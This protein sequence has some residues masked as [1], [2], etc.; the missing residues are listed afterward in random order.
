MIEYKQCLGCGN[1]FEVN[2]SNKN[3]DYCSQNCFVRYEQCIVC[4]KHFEVSNSQ[5]EKS[6]NICSEECLSVINKTQKK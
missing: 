1:Y 5:D 6:R 4:G 2:D 3:R